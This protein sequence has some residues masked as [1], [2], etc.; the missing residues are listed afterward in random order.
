MGEIWTL[1]VWCNYKFL[2]RMVF[3]PDEQK[4]KKLNFSVMWIEYV[5]FCRHL[6]KSLSPFRVQLIQ[7][8]AHQYICEALWKITP[9]TLYKFHLE[10]SNKLITQLHKHKGNDQQWVIF[11]PRKL[12][13][14]DI[15]DRKILY[16]VLFRN[17]WRD[18]NIAD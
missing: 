16:S 2:G 14:L 11:R 1:V 15:F 18:K 6:S 12:P 13:C 7:K 8:Q 17:T 3:T 4:I 9:C 10:H 5:T